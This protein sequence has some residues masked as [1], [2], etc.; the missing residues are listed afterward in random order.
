MRPDSTRDHLSPRDLGVSQHDDLAQS[1]LPTSSDQ[2]G[3]RLADFLHTVIRTAAEGICVCAECPDFPFVR[4]SVWNDRMTE[5]TGYT[6]A[7]I[8]QLGWYQTVY[9]DALIRQR[10]AERMARMRTGDDLRHEEWTITRKDGAERILAMSTSLVETEDGPAV[11]ALMSDSTERRQ[12]EVALRRSEARLVAAQR[13]ARIGSW[14]WDIASGAVWWSEELYRLFGLDPATFQP[15]LDSYLALVHRDDV[16]VVRSQLERT[17][18]EGNPYQHEVRIRRSDG[19]FRWKRCEGLLERSA[20]GAPVRMWGTAQDVTEQRQ[21]AETQRALEDQL[22]EARRLEGIGVL[23]AGFAHEF[24]NLLTTILGHA[25]LAQMELARTSPIQ[26]HIEPIRDAGRR[27]AEL[28]RKLL[29]YAGKG[30]LLL[31]PVD[32]NQ[33]VRDT[34]AKPAGHIDF[35]LA[36]ALPPIRADAEHL[37][38]MI[39]SVVANAVESG[40]RVWLATRRARLDSAAATRL[41]YP[42]KAAMNEF[43]TFEVRD[44]GLGMSESVLAKAFEPFFSTKFAGRGLGLPVALGVARAHEGGLDVMSMPGHGTT[45]R[46]YLPLQDS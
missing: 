31:G 6:M 5:I 32:L 41:R 37:R 14:E 3:R 35:N 9:P 1:E 20:S 10:A 19:M 8:N 16:G 17:L 34:V 23:S 21:V 25:D 29:A 24:N 45:V 22:R 18:Q 15:S 2:A 36:D 33:L 43:V 11:V 30:R 26:A 7:E 27:A 39:G 28:C 44:E 4:F 46:I 38:Q 42:P 12:A 40:G 13:M